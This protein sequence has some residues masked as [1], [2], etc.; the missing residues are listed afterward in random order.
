MPSELCPICGQTLEDY[1]RN[2]DQS[3]YD[4]PNCGR[5]VLSGRA[6][7]LIGNRKAESEVF[8]SGAFQIFRS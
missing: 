5:Y 4:C 6:R 2:G 3:Q 1:G 7:M 8:A